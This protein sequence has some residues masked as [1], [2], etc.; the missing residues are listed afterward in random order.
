MY[1]ASFS[2]KFCICGK[3]YNLRISYDITNLK[4]SGDFYALH[5]MVDFCRLS[6]KCA[7]VF[8]TNLLIKL[9]VFRMGQAMHIIFCEVS[10]T[11]FMLFYDLLV[12][13]IQNT[14]GS[15]I[16]ESAKTRLTTYLD[17]L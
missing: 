12:Q 14:F 4:K 16:A 9:F 8:Y 7:L 3:I 10:V 11:V 2:I 13:T 1:S 15:M 5:D 6:H 17:M